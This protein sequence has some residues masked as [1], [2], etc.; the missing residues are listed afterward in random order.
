MRQR[1][2]PSAGGG[3]RWGRRCIAVLDAGVAR[4]QRSKKSKSASV[5]MFCFEHL[6]KFSTACGLF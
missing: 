1:D 6:P 4:T 2:G 3:E 5:M